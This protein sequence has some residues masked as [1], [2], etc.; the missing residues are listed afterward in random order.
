MCRV[1]GLTFRVRATGIRKLVV[2]GPRLYRGLGFEVVTL[3]RRR[4]GYSPY[5]SRNCDRSMIATIGMPEAHSS[6]SASFI[7]GHHLPNL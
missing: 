1:T 4:F 7:V 2:S 5:P 6:L 3:C